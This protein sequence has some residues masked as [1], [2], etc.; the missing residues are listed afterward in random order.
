LGNSRRECRKQAGKP[1]LLYLINPVILSNIPR[2]IFFTGFAN[3]AIA[4]C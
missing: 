1:A 4:A 2:L 3:I